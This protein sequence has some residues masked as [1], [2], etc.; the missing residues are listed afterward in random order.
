MEEYV[1]DA[2]I[3]IVDFCKESNRKIPAQKLAHI[4]AMIEEIRDIRKVYF[5]YK[6]TTRDSIMDNL[7]LTISYL[8]HYKE[9]SLNRIKGLWQ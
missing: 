9:N 8:R 4:D 1:A 2:I 3:D 7:D 5:E 6:R